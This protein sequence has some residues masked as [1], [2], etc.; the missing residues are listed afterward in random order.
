M[1]ES[2]ATLAIGSELNEFKVEKVLGSGTFGITYLAHDNYLDKKVVIKEYFPNDIAIRQGDKTIAPKTNSD[3]GNFKYG[4]E[5]FLKEAQTLAKFNHPNIVKINSFFEANNTAYFV[6]DYEEG[7]DLESFL[8]REETINEKRILDIILPLLDGLQEVH[9]KS[10]LHRDIKPGNIYLK[11]NGTPMLIDFGATR[12]SIGVKSQSLSIILTPGYAPKEQYSSKSKQLNSTDIY[13]I[14]AVIYKMITGATPVEA[15]ERSDRITDDEADPHIKLMEM[16]YSKYSEKLKKA[17]DWAMEF[18]AKDRPQNVQE[19]KKALTQRVENQKPKAEEREDQTV[20]RVMTQVPHSTQE[21]SSPDNGNT[22][23]FIIGFLTLA[24]VIGAFFILNN[25]QNSENHVESET[26]SESYDKLKELE[27]QNQRLA[28]EKREA[29][30]EAERIKREAE[31]KEK[32][33]IAYEEERRKEKI[34]FDKKRF[35]DLNNDNINLTVSYPENVRRGEKVYIK[36]SLKNNGGSESRGGI[37]LSFPQLDYISGKVISNNFNT[38]IKSYGS[39]D[40]IW[41]K[42]ENSQI[43]AKYLMLESN[44]EQWIRN[45]KHSFTVAIDT[46]LDVNVFRVFVRA[47]LRNRVVPGDGVKDQQ[48]YLCKVITVNIV[49]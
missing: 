2:A 38:N 28:E 41:S 11:F 47:T 33:R 46:P 4:L 40:K 36:A 37:T 17:T 22:K 5:S 3:K 8:E 12:Y 42:S 49:D 18:K 29:Q 6:M 25:K 44:D 32:K 7:E 27:A 14:G 10:Y 13:S 31:E 26:K 20:E 15:S 24:I 16:S 23:N 1:G 35:L 48:G 9:G 19:L 34:D 39:S 21:G 43:Y 30:R 45:E